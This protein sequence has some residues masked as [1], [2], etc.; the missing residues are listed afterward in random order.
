MKCF[1][2][3]VLSPKHRD[4]DVCKVKHA[5]SQ[6]I[7]RYIQYQLPNATKSTSLSGETKK[8]DNVYIIGKVV[9]MEVLDIKLED[10]LIARVPPS[11]E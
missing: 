3:N 6:R 1:Y 9:G 2:M 4:K 8:G 5:L 10:C 7:T 11:K